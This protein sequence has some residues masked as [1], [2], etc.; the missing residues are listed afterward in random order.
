MAVLDKVLYFDCFAGASGDMI[1]GALL[2]LGLDLSVLEAELAKLHLAEFRVT[3]KK[4]RKAGFSATK[5]DVLDLNGLEF[6]RVEGHEHTEALHG[7]D[8]EDEHVHSHIKHAHSHIHSYSISHR[9]DHGRDQPQHHWHHH[10]H[11]YGDTQEREYEHE[12]EHQHGHQHSHTEQRNLDD[13]IK[14]ISNSDLAPAIKQR[15]I[16]IF[17]RLARAEAK[18]HGTV[19]ERIHFHEVGA[20]DAIVDI[21]GAVT[22][23]YLLGIAKIIISPLP[24]GKG[25]VRCQHG[26]IPVPAPATMEL[27]T[28]LQT[29]GSDHNGETVTPTGAAILATMAEAC[30]TM[31][32]LTIERIG[33][34]SGTRDFGVPNLLRAVLGT[35]IEDDGHERD[36]AFADFD[37]PVEEIISLE[38]N[39]DD[40][41]PELFAYAFDRLFQA[42]ALDVCLI[43]IM[44]KK[45]RP[46]Q[47]LCV[48][49]HEREMRAI[50][51]VIFRET[52][53][54]GVRIDRRQRFCLPRQTATV[55]T[56]FGEI[57]VKQAMFNGQVV[58]QA[59]EYEDCKAK[60]EQWDVPLKEIYVATL[61]AVH[62]ERN[63]PGDQDGTV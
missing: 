42:G 23:L 36:G 49:G 60:A 50:V 63:Q 48:L 40:M 19:P 51:N 31:P 61:R 29:Y 13:I 35:E 22:A 32:K 14:L 52:S 30:G 1:V 33:Y 39:I 57:R 7:H 21:V 18:I 26:L 24:L 59:P 34:G 47:I 58:N 4:V 55:N 2:D 9:Q 62:A 3:A 45:S 43:P 16:D 46:A 38:A 44:M 6:D 11:A 56:E 15:S 25:F 8:H 37:Y 10:G 27:L 53:T 20:V 12:H 41:N 17:W 54:I 5:F 28:G